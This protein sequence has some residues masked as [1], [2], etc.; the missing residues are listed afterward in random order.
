MTNLDDLVRYVSLSGSVGR[1]VDEVR[2]RMNGL[3]DT[4]YNALFEYYMLKQSDDRVFASEEFQN[5]HLLDNRVIDL[6]VMNRR[7]LSHIAATESVGILQSDLSAALKIDNKTLFHH[8]KPLIH[9]ELVTRIP[10]AAKRT[11]TYLCIL[12]KLFID[13]IAADSSTSVAGTL[14]K[15]SSVVTK[16]SI[17]STL[18]KEPSKTFTTKELYES[19]CPEGRDMK[20]FRRGLLSLVHDN[21]IEIMSTRELG[22]S[23]RLVKL[24]RGDKEV[25]E[26]SSLCDD[27][28]TLVMLAPSLVDFVPLERQVRDFIFSCGQA[29]TTMNE[30]ARNFGL[31]RKFAFRLME[32]LTD[33]KSIVNTDVSKQA[34]FVGRERRYRFKV[35]AGDVFLPLSDI[36]RDSITRLRRQEVLLDLLKEKKILE[37]GR[38]LANEISKLMNESTHMLDLKTLRRAINYLRSLNQVTIH[39][40]NTVNM[41]DRMSSRTFIT[42][43]QVTLGSAEFADLLR[44]IEVV[45]DES[46]DLDD[47]VEVSKYD[48][49]W[50]LGF[51]NRLKLA[52]RSVAEQVFGNDN[53]DKTVCT[54]DVFFKDL[55]LARY[56]RLIGSGSKMSKQY[57]EYSIDPEKSSL[58]IKLLPFRNELNARLRDHR[59]IVCRLVSVLTSL[60]LIV[61]RNEMEL[62]NNWKIPFKVD[63]QQSVS[64]NTSSSSSS[65]DKLDFEFKQLSDIDAFWDQIFSLAKV[66][67]KVKESGA[68]SFLFDIRNWVDRPI[69]A[70][71][72]RA[73]ES[74][75]E[76]VC[77]EEIS[78]ESAIQE[79]SEA[80]GIRQS[81]I[82][83]YLEYYLGLME[84][85]QVEEEEEE[86][87]R[88]KDDH[89]AVPSEGDKPAKQRRKLEL[90]MRDEESDKLKLLLV[91][92]EA[93]DIVIE[94]S[95]WPVLA[96]LFLE[97]TG[98]ELRKKHSNMG[99]SATEQASIKK[100]EKRILRIDQLVQ[101]GKIEPKPTIPNQSIVDQIAGLY[102]WYSECLAAQSDIDNK[103]MLS[104]PRSL[105]EALQSFSFVP[106]PIKTDACQYVSDCFDPDI[107][108][109]RRRVIFEYLKT[110]EVSSEVDLEPLVE[111]GFI[112]RKQD[113]VTL[114]DKVKKW[115][116]AKQD[117]GLDVPQK[118][119]LMDGEPFVYP[120]MDVPVVEVFKLSA[121]NCMTLSCTVQ[122]INQ[123]IDYSIAIT[124][125]SFDEND[126]IGNHDLIW[127]DLNGKLNQSILY[128]SLGVVH[129]LISSNPG[130][131]RKQLK[132]SLLSQVELDYSVSCLQSNGYIT[133]IANDCLFPV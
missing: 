111:Y 48:F 27:V 105:A 106:L 119:M 76:R 20:Y 84:K 58:S 82:A 11:F 23:T 52:H 21:L 19:I 14:L 124:K 114:S 8:L 132:S 107:L 77:D 59:K 103:I 1:T 4:A 73:I 97:R 6:T 61:A 69:R 130:I 62:K 28:D 18:L 70:T 78:S 29:G 102:S 35:S 53:H 47:A 7:A 30:I 96:E 115:L 40:V 126:F 79:L 17:M 123:Q 57:Y 110:G 116:D 81:V 122:D 125:P 65:A 94:G 87:E 43:P 80:Y 60:G 32:R 120:S 55:S 34:E 38:A 109:A 99:K 71:T 2:G 91:L 68:N 93:K 33:K 101:L 16:E 113:K 54:I 72:L 86:E 42:L 63:F 15:Q 129:E 95:P 118:L 25:I 88:D 50:Q 98:E 46:F 51:M 66:P 89:A 90:P 108:S 37:I 133:S 3:T 56:H 12:S 74:A 26:E 5:I 9:F 100:L 10:V 24:K 64:I 36:S 49:G 104:N 112:H 121:M 117:F 75:A 83:V 85:D 41:D 22:G 67:E 45:K 131:P 44:S 127:I 31:G 13:D 39:E 128:K 92:V